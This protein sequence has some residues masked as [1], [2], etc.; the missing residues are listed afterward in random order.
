MACLDV[1][2]R[3]GHQP[4]TVGLRHGIGALAAQALQQQADIGQLVG[5]DEAVLLEQRIVGRQAGEQLDHGLGDAEA[6]VQQVAVEAELLH[7]GLHVRIGGEVVA[8]EVLADRRAEQQVLGDRQVLVVLVDVELLDQPGIGRLLQPA[9]Q[10]VPHRQDLLGEIGALAGVDRAAQAE[11]IDVLVELDMLQ[12]LHHAGQ[13]VGR[14]GG[15]RQLV[16]DPVG[17]GIER[18]IA[19]PLRLAPECLADRLCR[20]V[21]GRR[22]DRPVLQAEQQ[23]VAHRERE[24]VGLLADVGRPRAHDVFGHLEEILVI[25]PDRAAGRLHEP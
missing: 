4:G 14:S 24:Q 9:V 2:Q 13:Q 23:V 3:Q 7:H 15:A 18:R 5:R 17:G 21:V 10:L 19:G 25:E 20:G 22:G 11:R 6:H 8:V 1:A 16:V 12:H